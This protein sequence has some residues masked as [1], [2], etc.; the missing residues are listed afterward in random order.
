LQQDFDGYGNYGGPRHFT[1][2]IS[3][4]FTSAV[5]AGAGFQTAF[6]TTLSGLSMSISTAENFI[7]NAKQQVGQ[8]DINESLV[9]AITELTAEVKRLEEEVRRVKRDV[10][11]GRRF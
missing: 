4:R 8:R 5:H 2:R 1:T 3:E 10:Q 7:R 11:V 6:P 9:R